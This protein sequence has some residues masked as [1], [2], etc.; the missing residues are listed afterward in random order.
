MSYGHLSTDCHHYHDIVVDY[1]AGPRPEIVVLC[2]ST[3]F[4]ETF[5]AENLRL[6][7]AGAIVL[8]IGCDTTADGDLTTAGQLGQDPDALKARL[9]ALHLRKIDLA[10]RVHVL[11]LDGY[12]GDSTRREIE[13]ATK[14]GKPITYLSEVPA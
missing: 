9:D 11:D 4:H 2:G 6:T 7:L 10:D 8:S 13:Y 14:L 1:G 12:L 3:R 5:R